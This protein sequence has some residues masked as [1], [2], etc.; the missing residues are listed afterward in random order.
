MSVIYSDTLKTNRMQL[1]NDLTNSKVAAASTGG[2]STGKLVIG[3]SALSG[4]T[5]VLATIV[6]PNPGFTVSTPVAGTVIATLL[7]VPL[8][9]ASAG[10]GTAA[11]AQ[12]R[13]T[14]DAVIVDNLTVGLS[15]ADIILNSLS[16]T[17]PQT[18]TV[19][20]GVVTHG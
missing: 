16:I 19:S 11:K 14:A 18:V 8:S 13:N 17:A 15:A 10:S 4:A 5:G 6:I 2:G 3:T 9:V 20:S 1:V 7:G 12:I